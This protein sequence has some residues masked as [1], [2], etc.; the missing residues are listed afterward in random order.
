MESCLSIDMYSR[1]VSVE[2]AR[3]LFETSCTRNTQNGLI[4]QAL[5]VLRQM[6]DKSSGPNAMTLTSILTAR[7]PLGSL[8]LG[9]QLHAYA[10]RNCLSLLI[11]LI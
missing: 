1:C 4:E 7:N 11:L 10:I 5:I 3:A 8:A 9:K 6:L 2:A